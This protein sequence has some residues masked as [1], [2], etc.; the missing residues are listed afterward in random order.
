MFSGKTEEVI[1]RL[2]RATIANQQVAI[3][4]P[5]MDTRYSR[6]NI[7]SH[8]YNQLS[9]ISIKMAEEIL[10]DKNPAQVI[11]IDEAQFFSKILV[12]V[13][14]I[15]A[16]KGKRVIVAGLD[17]DYLGRPFGPIPELMAVA[18]YVTKIHAICVI[19]GSLASHSYRKSPNTEHVLVGEKEH[20]EPRCRYCFNQGIEES[21]GAQLL[22]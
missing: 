3:Y 16:G 22:L 6:E 1:R 10:Y 17:M 5:E 7:V 14:Q 13:V 15:L 12:R 11:G 4:K 19:C 20:Y 9:S 18:E 21:G 8:D 2:K